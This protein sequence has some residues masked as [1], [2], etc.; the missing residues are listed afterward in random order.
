MNPRW[1]RTEKRASE[2]Q[3][4]GVY[5]DIPRGAIYFWSENFDWLVSVGK[6]S[7]FAS[8]SFRSSTG[9]SIIDAC[10]KAVV[11]G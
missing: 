11:G 2:L 10:A 1:R 3:S 7:L 4:L 6:A 9:S 8:A 5:C